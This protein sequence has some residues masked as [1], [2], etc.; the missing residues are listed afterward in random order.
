VTFQL[1]LLPFGHSFVDTE[2]QLVITCLLKTADATVSVPI[3]E[4]IVGLSLSKIKKLFAGLNH[5]P[6]LLLT[7]LA[8]L[9]Q[10]RCRLHCPASPVQ[11]Q[12]HQP[13]CPALFPQ[14]TCQPQCQPSLHR[15]CLHSLWVQSGEI[16]ERKAVLMEG[17]GLILE[18]L[19]C[20]QR[21]GS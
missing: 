17:T 8:A 4:I 18:L 19:G 21:L 6:T 1:V 13:T 15:L 10:R 3:W 12:C 9:Q 14:R 20:V 16:L 2:I 5:P 11:L 7:C